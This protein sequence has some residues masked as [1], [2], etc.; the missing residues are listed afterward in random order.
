MSEGKR[1]IVDSPDVAQER[2]RKPDSASKREMKRQEAKGK[3]KKTRMKKG[4][5]QKSKISERSRRK[6][7]DSKFKD[8]HLTA[9]NNASAFLETNA[10]HLKASN[11]SE[12]HSNN[13]V[14]QTNVSRAELVSPKDSESHLKRCEDVMEHRQ[15]YWMAVC[16]VIFLFFSFLH[17][18]SG[19]NSSDLCTCPHSI[20]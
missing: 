10:P 5:G 18:R 12:R 6:D 3:S 13:N 14:S 20:N 4:T 9:N 8:T 15:W 1:E 17:F 7:K 11:N 2:W 19:N 16:R